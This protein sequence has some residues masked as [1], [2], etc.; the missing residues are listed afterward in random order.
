MATRGGSRQREPLRAPRGKG[1]ATQA[2]AGRDAVCYDLDLA[3]AYNE[4]RPAILS[5]LRRRTGDVQLAEDLMQEVFLAAL[6]AQP[7]LSKGCAPLLAWLYAVARR[8]AI[9]AAR[10]ARRAARAAPEDVSVVHPSDDGRV[11]ARAIAEAI[12][13][14]PAEEQRVVLLRL[15]G[16]CSFAE[17]GSSRCGGERVSGALQPGAA[18]VAQVPRSVGRRPADRSRRAGE[19][20]PRRCLLLRLSGSREK[21]IRRPENRS[22]TEGGFRW[23]VVA[24]AGRLDLR[25]YAS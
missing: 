3:A 11:S 20:R 12:R 25:L 4:Y 7:S 21:P 2:R 23:L 6:V 22:C 19:R 1:S 5:Y 10:S 14:L 18:C 24:L 8:R 9:D 16:G 15:F 17:I 13:A